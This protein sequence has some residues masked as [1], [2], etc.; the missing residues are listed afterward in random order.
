MF[1]RPPR[2]FRG[3]QRAAS[4]CSSSSSSAEGEP[5][6]G[7]AQGDEEQEQGPARPAAERQ[8]PAEGP[9]GDI[10]G[11][12]EEEDGGGGV[13]RGANPRAGQ[14]RGATALLSFGADEERDGKSLTPAPF[15]HAACVGVRERDGDL[16]V[17]QVWE[18]APGWSAN[19]WAL[20]LGPLVLG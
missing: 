7:G 14:A 2:N 3:R 17:L 5:E 10:R 19:S 11:Q 6:Y 15:R 18:Q 1:R 12:E 8:P 20:C 16:L 4:S 13:P 9:A